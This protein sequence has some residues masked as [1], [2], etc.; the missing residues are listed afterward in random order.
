MKK[1][2]TFAWFLISIFICNT[3][4][5]VKAEEGGNTAYVKTMKQD[6]LCLMMAYPE[7]IVNLKQNNGKVYLIL[8]SGKKVVYD[9]M[10]NKSYEEKLSNPDLQDMME[11][12]Y[13]LSFPT[14]LMSKNFD[15]GRSRVYGLLN[16]VYGSSSS[17]VQSR[18]KTVNVRYGSFQFNGSNN[19]ANEL[20]AAFQELIP[21]ADGNPKVKA[22]LLPTSG[23]FNYRFIAGTNRLSPH[24]FAIAI[25]L[26]RDKRDYWQ[27]ASQA[28]GQK[29]LLSYPKEVVEVFERHGFVWGG[30]WNHFDILHFEYRPEIILKAKLFGNSKDK[31]GSW[32]DGINNEDTKL[33]EYI[34]KIDETIG[35]L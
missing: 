21:I 3:G 24:S 14:A 26:A 11:T 28:E 20:K 31:S 8:K 30:K 9:D 16:E 5:L 18:L 2:K 6:I 34:N 25:D 15:P 4:V 17:Q 32:C 33:K 27:W 29:R 7:H 19:A 35:S 13:P 22:A 12:I 1:I 23:T 10:R